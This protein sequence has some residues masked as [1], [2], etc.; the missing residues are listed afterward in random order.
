MIDP[1]LLSRLQKMLRLQGSSNPNE[2]ANAAAFVERICRDAGITPSSLSDFDEVDPERDA[3][4]KEELIFNGKRI[5]VAD[6]WLLHI[7]AKHFNGTTVRTDSNSYARVEIFAT[8]AQM[9]QIRLFYD[10]IKSAMDEQAESA[11]FLAMAR[12]YSARGFKATF[13]KNFTAVVGQRL[14]EMRTA[15]QTE[16]LRSPEDANHVPGLVLRNRAEME[17]SRAEALCNL[18]YPRLRKGSSVS[19][20]SGAAASAGRAAGRS[21]GLSTQLASSS[22]RSLSPAR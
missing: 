1:T 7:V 11:K 9:I 8:Q 2:A 3:A 15:Q 12:G 19:L 17:L 18:K 13:C 5:P 4:T 14:R 20:G 6:P 22:T 10:Y 16:G 21:I